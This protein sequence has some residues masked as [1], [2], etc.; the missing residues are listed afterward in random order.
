M[1]LP[2][3]IYDLPDSTQNLTDI[4]GASVNLSSFKGKVLII[5]N[6]ASSWGAT[7]KN[8]QQLNELYAKYKSQGLEI[9]MFP[10]NQ[11]MQEPKE[12]PAIKSFVRDEWKSEFPLFSKILVNGSSAHPLWTYLRNKLT[13]KISTFLLIIIIS[14]FLTNDIKWN[15][16]KFFVIVTLL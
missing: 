6:S 3:T 8:F 1:S 12:N 16:C 10:S 2:N 14:G 11:F 9:L 15:V 7:A 13:Y 4:D 5:V